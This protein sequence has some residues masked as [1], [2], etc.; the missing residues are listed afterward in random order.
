MKAKGFSKLRSAD[1]VPASERAVLEYWDRVD[2]FARSVD[3]R[4]PSTPFVFYE[5]PPTANGRPGVHH[6]IAR[7]C[8]DMICRYKTMRGY[9]VVRKAGWDTHGLP[10]E[11]EVENELGIT[12]KEEIE[13]YGVAEF[14]RKCRE[15]VFRY[16]KDWVEFTRRIGFWLDM[17]HPYIT[18]ENDYIESV[19]WILRRFWD[20]GLVYQGHKIVPFCPRC[21][22]SLSSHEVSQGYKDVSDPSIYIK[23]KRE[24]ADEYFLVWTTTP[25]TLISNVALAVGADHAYARV[26]HGGATLVLAEALLG[27]LDG[28]YEVVDTMKGADLVGARYEPLFDF[29]KD[30]AGAFRVVAADFVSLEDGTGIVHIAPAFG[31]DDYQLHLKEGVP[32]VQPVTPGGRFTD[33]V[34]PWAGQFIKDADPSITATLKREGKLYKSGKVTHSYPFCWRCHT[35]LVYYARRSWYIKTT[36]YKDRMIAANRKINWIPREVGE[37]RF[38]NWLE[39]NVDWSLSRERYWGTPL[40]IWVC[41]ACGHRHSVGSFAELEEMA[42][43]GFP[44][45]REDFD[46]H[47][48][49]VDDIVLACPACGGGMRRVSEV[50]D[51]WF[52]SGSMPFAQYH[53]PFDDPATF[54]SQFPADFISEG[55]DQS[56]G[57][58]YSLLAIAVFLKG[59]SS[60]RNCLTTELILDKHGQKMS[61]SRGNTV[62]PQDLLDHEGADALRWYLS[63]TS[64]PWSPTRFDRDGVTET[65]R[66]ML[67]TIRNVYSFFAMYA[68]IDGYRPGRSDDAR[69]PGQSAPGQSGERSLLDRW[70]LSRFH[71]TARTVREQMDVFDVTR[72]ARNIQNFVLDELSNWYVRRSRRRFWKGEMGPDKVAAYDTL[73][74]VLD[75]V[76]RLLAPFTPFVAEEVYLA[77]RGATPETGDGASVH[78]ETYPE[79]D[80]SAVDDALEAQMEVALTVVSLGRTVRNDAAMKIRQPL[81]RMLV[82]SSDAASLA[83]F[84]DNPSIVGL[85]LDE[86]NIREVAS[87]STLDDYVRRSATPNFPALGRRFGKKVPIVADAI[88]ALD[89]GTLA[90]FARTGS[91]TVDVE[92]APTDLSRD[93]LSVQLSAAGGFGAREER[94]VTVILDLTLTREL[95]LEGAAREIV[96]RVQ[97]LRKQ[98]GYDVTDRIRLRYDG[99][100]SAGEVFEAQGALI[101]AETLAVELEPGAADWPDHVE[102]SLAG[103][104]VRLWIT[105][106]ID[107]SDD[108]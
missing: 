53:Y 81:S 25:W 49:L 71:S 4:S 20:Q 84:L 94:G 99:A 80:P 32:L 27:V 92:G 43:S 14:N 63:T 56:R 29:F 62:A 16:E 26:R 72:A 108:R 46:P 93:E 48:P 73:F 90:A 31:E 55:I 23:F 64:P 78:L 11:I 9:R 28:D 10:V 34:T 12:R 65:S 40:N 101:G 37:H 97:N 19:W 74:T 85:V 18:C 91:V 105:K 35:P 69:A 96:N 87:V 50:I 8:K 70:I 68:E 75:G 5:G 86:L 52:D 13:A 42:T 103:T 83:A 59:E 60:Y 30:E 100:A 3:E 107:R 17:D 7:L 41:E 106:L 2:T 57:W 39:N 67:D 98:A 24:D 95:E 88:K 21:E 38:G 33:D 77:L 89:A 102:L 79:P 36:A 45:R 47:R 51:V 15:S 76:L 22:T 61:K 66:K 1:D 82:H 6:V 54:D 44:D 104:T 58:F